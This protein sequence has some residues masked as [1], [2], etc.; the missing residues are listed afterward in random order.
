MTTAAKDVNFLSVSEA[1]SLD[2]LMSDGLL[3]LSPFNKKR[4]KTVHLLVT[5]LKEDGIIEKAMF[6]LYLTKIPA[7]SKMHFGGYDKAIVENAIKENRALG[8]DD[9]VKAPD[10]I[11]WMDIN[12][13]VHWQV[14][15]YDA[16]IGDEVLHEAGSDYNMIFDSGS[17]LSYIPK[18]SYEIFLKE[19]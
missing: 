4:D 3:G 5:Q 16:K 1:K 17:S 8:L 14:K 15:I 11:Y 18:K 10:G 13:D 7:Q 2:T 6:A 9:V 19:I 12:S